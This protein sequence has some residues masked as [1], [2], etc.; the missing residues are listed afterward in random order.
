MEAFT[1]SKMPTRRSYASL[2]STREVLV[3]AGGQDTNGEMI[4]VVEVLL[5]DKWVSVDPLPSPVCEM[6]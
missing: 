4:D 3:V 1:T 6:R 5:Q 2:L